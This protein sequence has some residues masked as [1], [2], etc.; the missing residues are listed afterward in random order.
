MN[1]KSS[2][3]DIL[4]IMM[5]GNTDHLLSKSLKIF[6]EYG[7]ENKRYINISEVYAQLRPSISS[8]L[9]GFH[10]LTDCDFNPP[11]FKTATKR[12]FEILIKRAA[13]QKAL[14]D[15]GNAH[16]TGCKAK[17]SK[18]IEKFGKL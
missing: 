4:V 1:I 17:I 12:C 3:T 2:V 9:Q 5:L 6:K 18:I 11:F 8:N 13:Y 10:A 7:T 15:V 16:V 14:R